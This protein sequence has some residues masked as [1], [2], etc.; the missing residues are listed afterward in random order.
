MLSQIKI[1]LFV[2]LFVL[3]GFVARA[4]D[5]DYLKHGKIFCLCSFHLECSYC[6]NCEGERYAVKLDNHSDKKITNV[7]YSYYSAPY[8]KIVE[9]EGSM[10]IGRIY[11]QQTGVVHICV[12]NGIHWIISKIVYDDGSSNKFVL[13]ERMENFHQDPD[14]CDCND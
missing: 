10:E 3:G 13:H 8:N 9:K 11:G 2:P 6:D 7:F 12:P 4:Q 14:E 1:Y 5:N